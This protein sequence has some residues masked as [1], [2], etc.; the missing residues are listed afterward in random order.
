RLG[1]RRR[2]LQHF[3]FHM[4]RIAR[5]DRL[6]PQQ[7]APT[8]H[9]TA[10]YRQA[11]PDDQPHRNPRSVPAAGDKAAEQRA[12]RRLILHMERLRIIVRCKANDVRRIHRMRPT[13]EALS[14]GEIFQIK[15]L[16][17]TSIAAS[18]AAGYAASWR[19]DRC[20]TPLCSMPFAPSSAHAAY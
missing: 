8:P 7:L 13:D 11:A 6:R 16:H 14:H 9:D 1:T 17:P 20:L 10:R 19:T 15:R 2:H 3:T 5:P 12:T 18:A 4:Q